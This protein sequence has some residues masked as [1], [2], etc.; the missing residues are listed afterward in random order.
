MNKPTINVTPL[1]DVLLVLLIIFM[2]VAPLRPSSFKTRIPS[3]SSDLSNGDPHPLLLVAAIESDGSLSLNS[4]RDLGTAADPSKLTERLRKVFAERKAIVQ[5]S[6]VS[7]K[8]PKPNEEGSVERTVF[9]KAPRNAS[10][11]AVAGVIDA[12]KLSGA[13]PIGLQIDGL[14]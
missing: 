12:V 10:Y 8:D 13:Y 7:S 4:Q 11:G 5:D 14:Q 9:V 2:V 6:I 1:I 3:E